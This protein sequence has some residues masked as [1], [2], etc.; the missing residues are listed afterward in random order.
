[1][2]EFR[3]TAIAVAVSTAFLLSACAG[4]GGGSG[5]SPPVTPPPVTTPPA[6]NPYLRTEVPYYTPVLQA[7]VDPLVNVID[8]G[9]KWA[10]ADTFAADITGTGG[11]D[12]IVAGRMTQWT[13]KEEWGENR[14]SLLA[15]QL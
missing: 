4:G 13:P 2:R 10:V 5:A 3:K 1:M 9:Y 15:W 12:L 7:V 11:H 14:I 6:P 8:N